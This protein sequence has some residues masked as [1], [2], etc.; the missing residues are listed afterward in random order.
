MSTLNSVTVNYNQGI[1][2]STLVKFNSSAV[3]QAEYFT[4]TQVLGVIWKAS[5]KQYFYAEVTQAEFDGLLKAASAGAYLTALKSKKAEVQ[6]AEAASAGRAALNL[7]KELMMHS[8][9]NSGRRHNSQTLR[10]ATNFDHKGFI[11]KVRK[12]LA[13]GGVVLA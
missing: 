6:S 3:T 11:S 2:N 4:E 7:L 5:G 9:A 1:A 12:T 8:D 13:A 10:I